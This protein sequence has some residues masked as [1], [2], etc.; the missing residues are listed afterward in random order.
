MPNILSERDLIAELQKQT[1]GLGLT[2]REDGRHGLSGQAEKIRAK[3][4]LGGSK[5]D[6]RMS[7]RLTEPDHIAHFREAVVER[8]WGI[9]P[10]TLTVETTSVSGWKRSGERH[11]ASVGGGG[12]LDYAKVRDAM[13]TAI[14]AAGWKFQLKVAARLDGVSNIKHTLSRSKRRARGRVV[15]NRNIWPSTCPPPVCRPARNVS[16]QVTHLGTC[17]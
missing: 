1:A 4:W 8:S 10:P 2:V 11:D 13:E 5:V 12:S 6:Y 17:C 15:F 16:Y 9:P 14:V 3:W 7:C